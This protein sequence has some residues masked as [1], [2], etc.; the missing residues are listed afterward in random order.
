VA[1]GH[2]FVRIVLTASSGVGVKRSVYENIEKKG[3]K[4]FYYFNGNTR[5]RGGYTSTNR[6][7][8]FFV[9]QQRAAAT[10][11]DWPGLRQNALG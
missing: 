8:L 3:V 7:A 11:C 10:C 6:A 9:R 2:G 5:R 1:R 4:L